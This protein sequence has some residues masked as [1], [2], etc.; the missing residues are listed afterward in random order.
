LSDC[1]VKVKDV[2]ETR[3]LG[4]LIASCLEGG[5]VVLLFGEIGCGKTE[6]VKGMATFFGIPPE[7]VSSPSFTIVHE[8]ESFVHVDLYRL[9]SRVELEDIDIYRLLQD[10]RVKVVE[11][12]TLVEGMVPENK[13]VKIQCFELSE[14]ERCFVVTD[15]TGRVC[16]FIIQNF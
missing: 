4:R 13:R 15:G 14:T 12:A 2:Q 9:E 11:W 5:T 3:R 7:D 16:P 8:Y 1:T 6:L 10:S